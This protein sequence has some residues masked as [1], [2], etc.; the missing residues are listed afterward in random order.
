M[1]GKSVTDVLMALTTV[2]LASTLVAS[3]NTAQVFR[4]LGRATSDVFLA[5][6]GKRP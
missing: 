6:Q 5:A 1:G 2:A 3:R 4:A